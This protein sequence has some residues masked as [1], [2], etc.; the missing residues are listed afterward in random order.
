M[1]R[2]ISKIYDMAA[3]ENKSIKEWDLHH[4]INNSI[5]NITTEIKLRFNN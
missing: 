1:I 2:K 3:S 4:K 5:K